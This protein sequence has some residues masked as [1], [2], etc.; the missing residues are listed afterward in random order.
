[1]GWF[2]E[3]PGGLN[4]MYYNL[5]QRL[6]ATGVNV[7]GLVTG[8]PSLNST[9]LPS[10]ATI[11]PFAETE[12]F[13]PK[14]LWSARK[15][16]S[17]ILDKQPPD[18]VA[19]HF[20]LYTLPWL[21]LLEDVPLVIH[22]HGPWAAEGKVETA[23]AHSTRI[24][25]WVEQTVYDRADLL[26]VLSE[27]FQSLLEND[28]GIPPQRIVRVPGGVDADKFDVTASR[29]EARAR[30]GWPQD[31]SVVFSIRRLAKR[32][33]LENLIAAVDEVRQTAPEVILMIAGKG[34]MFNELRAHISERN[35][36]DHVTL[37]GF[38][39][40][41]D[42]PFA[43]RAANISVVPTVALEGFGLITIESLAAGT[44]VLVTPV[45][46]LPEVVKPLS[47]SLVLDGSEPTD[48]SIGILRSIQ[49]PE[50]LPS[51]EECQNYVCK[52]FDWPII[53]QKIKKTYC[54]VLD[55]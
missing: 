15:S 6:P 13:L 23:S 33:G 29:K 7:H 38:V 49:Y 22:F 48:L 17:Q 52:N 46:G 30:L 39:P 18:L 53:A 5:V 37:L 41:D 31:R 43:Y 36:Q 4:R 16:A 11:T 19:S 27:A 14:R 9:L 8:T 42:L 24:K 2:P 45:G 3:Q 32:M 34:P 10:S 12:T 40:E 1:M 54:C 44:P 47:S 28:Y 35:M 26:I 55:H 21:D 51:F 20:A 25:K 50:M